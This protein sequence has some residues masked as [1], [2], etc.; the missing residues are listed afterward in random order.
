[1]LIFSQFLNKLPLRMATQIYNLSWGDAPF[2]APVV[3]TN[4]L[5]AYCKS[6]NQPTD[7]LEAFFKRFEEV[8]EWAVMRLCVD[9]VYARRNDKTAI[10]GMDAVSLLGILATS[11]L[12][13]KDEQA[14]QAF[15]GADVKK[16]EYKKGFFNPFPDC[17]LWV[18]QIAEHN[19]FYTNAV[20]FLPAFILKNAQYDSESYG[21]T[22]YTITPYEDWYWQEYGKNSLRSLYQRTRTGGYSANFLQNIPITPFPYAG[23][24][25]DTTYNRFRDD[26]WEVSIDKKGVHIAHLPTANNK[27][28]KFGELKLSS[29]SYNLRNDNFQILGM[30]EDCLLLVGDGSLWQIGANFQ[31]QNFKFKTVF[32]KVLPDLFKNEFLLGVKNIF[33]ISETSAFFLLHGLPVKVV[34]NMPPEL[35]FQQFLELTGEQF[36]F[37]ALEDTI[38]GGFWFVAGLGR[39]VFVDKAF[40][41]GYTFNLTET[42][43]Y[44]ATET[45]TRDEKIRIRQEFLLKYI[46]TKMQWDEEQN[47]YFSL[48]SQIAYQI[49]RAEL[50]AKLATAT[51]FK[52]K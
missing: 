3:D 17:P 39:I 51:V 36:F 13:E 30:Q 35:L 12:S 24:Q 28:F 32:K 46:L 29:S 21:F 43:T 49:S 1:M 38:L 19:Q 11:F 41:K 25:N 27:S 52:T 10:Q 22:K 5:R 6:Y 18:L 7:E 34:K 42:P 31:V 23:I 16:F 37:S 50:T 33:K 2:C 26:F 40:Q 48:S 9:A 20:F 4:T 15:L 14:L 47:L 8:K 45:Y 44:T